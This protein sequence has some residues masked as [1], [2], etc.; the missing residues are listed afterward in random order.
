MNV[1]ITHL[2]GWTVFL[3][4]GIVVLARSAVF[5][6]WQQ[7][8][9]DSN[10]A[11]IGL[12]AKHV[13][14]LRTF[15]VFMY[16]QNYQLAVEA[17]LAAPLF[18]VGGASVTALKLPLLAMN[19]A[20]A[21][22]LLW[23]LQRDSGLTQAQAGVATVFFALAPP[24]TAAQLLEASGGIVEPLIYVLLL[25]V[26]RR[27]PI[28]CGLILGVGF[29][30]R[31]FAIYGFAALLILDAVRGAL[32]TRDHL[33]RTVITVGLAAA[34]WTVVQLAARVGPAVGP[35]TTVADLRPGDDDIELANRVCLDLS[36]VPV[37]IG[38]IATVHWP[39]LFGTR[40]QRLTR[41]S[42]ESDGTQGMNGLWVVL[43]AAMLLAA[44]RIATHISGERRWRPEYDFCAYLV[45]AGLLSIGG[46][47][48]ARCGVIDIFRMRYDMLS[49]IGAVGLAG[50]Y[51][52]IERSRWLKGAWV[53]LVLSWAAVGAAAHGRLWLEYLRDPPVGGKQQIIHHLNARG[54]RYGISE[55]RDAYVVSFLTDERIIMASD[56]VRIRDY[57]K[58]VAAHRQ[59]A[60]RIQRQS[61]PGG[62]RV[63]RGIFFCP[64]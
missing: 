16:G 56:R 58:E 5:V 61:C 29:V 11:V 54:I 40:V 35:G 60:V 44:V 38:R 28:W 33:K 36:T 6:F 31:E 24:G 13:A 3:V 27:R 26:T 4:V 30:H 23:S 37:G 9:F 2:P 15:P 55:Y 25:W 57:Q 1:R 59:E 48:V 49:I 47:V 52:R 41:F 45:L 17:W 50:W 39:L 7:S 20:V 12:M 22:L 42:I 34:V 64:P 8:F 14:E 21:F 53:V 19:L 51:L 18:L 46:Y 32:F 10:Q 43:A 63:M 62:E